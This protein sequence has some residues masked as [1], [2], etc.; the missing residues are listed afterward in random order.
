M[1]VVLEELLEL[2]P[3]A[4]VGFTMVVLCSVFVAGD[5]AAPVAGV[6][7]VRCSHAPR[8]AALARRQMIFF[9]FGGLPM[10]G[11]TGIAVTAAS[12]LT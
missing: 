5:A 1:V 2:P 10:L 3:P 11:Q 9:I 4:G 7:S 8:S 12:G 6:T